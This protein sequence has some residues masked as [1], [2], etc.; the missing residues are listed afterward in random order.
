MALSPLDTDVHVELNHPG[1]VLSEGTSREVVQLGARRCQRPSRYQNA[2]RN[3]V[4]QPV[5]SSSSLTV[6]SES[7]GA[8]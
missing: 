3:R 4:F 8:Q 7:K 6:V 1:F 5:R 2:Q